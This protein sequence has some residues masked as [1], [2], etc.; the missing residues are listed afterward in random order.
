M[1]S[2][3]YMSYKCFILN[4]DKISLDSLVRLCLCF[5][6]AHVLE[7]RAPIKYFIICKTLGFCTLLSLACEKISIQSNTEMG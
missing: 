1:C 6:R 4:I 5:L 7:L 3:I 2:N